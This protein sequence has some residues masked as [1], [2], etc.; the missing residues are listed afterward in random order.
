MVEERNVVT[1]SILTLVTCGIWRLV[2][3]VQIGRD[4][5]MLRGDDRPNVVID[6]LLS[7][8][9]CGIW[10][11]VMSYQWPGLLNE[12]LEQRGQRVDG[13]LPAMSLLMALFGFGIV[14]LILI[15]GELN[16]LANGRTMAL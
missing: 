7:F 5:A 15:Q 13:N 11:L 6:L 10:M 16:K 8:V 12:A 3:L 1:W 9:T 2:W 14:D 4:I